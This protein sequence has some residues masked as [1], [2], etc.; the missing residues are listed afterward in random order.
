MLSWKLSERDKAAG[1]ACNTGDASAMQ[2]LS[3][4]LD[5]KP[6]NKP[7]PLLELLFS[8]LI[9]SVAHIELFAASLGSSILRVFGTNTVFSVSVEGCSF[10]VFDGVLRML[11]S[12]EC[13]PRVGEE[14]PEL[15]GDWFREEGGEVING[16]L[17]GGGT[18]Q[19]Q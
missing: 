17:H 1:L 16:T 11:P 8:A 3:S 4:A 10:S 18:A 15:C 9:P 13:F 14:G 12:L 19:L 6:L 2:F 7:P 5:W